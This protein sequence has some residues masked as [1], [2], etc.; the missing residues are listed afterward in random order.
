[1]L[2][3]SDHQAAVK[4]LAWCPW[5]Q[6][7][8][9]SGGGTADRCI[10]FWNCNTGTCFSTIDTKSQVCWYLVPFYPLTTM[11]SSCHN[12]QRWHRVVKIIIGTTDF[13]LFL[14]FIVHDVYVLGLFVPYGSGLMFWRNV[15]PEDGGSISLWNTGSTAQWH[16]SKP[17]NRIRFHR[18]LILSGS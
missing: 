15:L 2:G 18:K 12:C 17:Q 10:R 13:M 5:Q 14:L 7:V 11:T 16:V 3:F 8:L 1:M 9:A 4:A 6:N